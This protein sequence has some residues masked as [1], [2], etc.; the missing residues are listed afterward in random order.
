VAGLAGAFGPW[1]LAPL[2]G[3]DTAALP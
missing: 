3:W 2:L 1:E